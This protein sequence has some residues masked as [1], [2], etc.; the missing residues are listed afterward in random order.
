MIM[1]RNSFITIVRVYLGV[2]YS[3][4]TV[5]LVKKANTVRKIRHLILLLYYSILL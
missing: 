4:R 3:R 2:Q 1:L 5:F